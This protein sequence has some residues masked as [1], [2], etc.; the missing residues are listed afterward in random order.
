MEAIG[1]KWA[2]ICAA[3]SLAAF[4]IVIAVT[5]EKAVAS[6]ATRYCPAFH[7]AQRSELDSRP[8]A[9]AHARQNEK[10]HRAGARWASYGAEA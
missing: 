2:K 10:A 5:N 3:G 6:V 7:D 9:L 1:R 4:A 8:C